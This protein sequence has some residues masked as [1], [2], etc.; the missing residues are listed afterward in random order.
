MFGFD[1]NKGSGAKLIITP[2]V[3]SIVLM[4]MINNMMMM[5]MNLM[6]KMMMMISFS[7]PGC[8]RVELSAYIIYV[9][10]HT[11]YGCGYSS[12]RETMQ[13]GR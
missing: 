3:M 8:E 1:N 4:F 5:I 11:Y 6:V 2:G 13:L 7:S 12:T 10:H 9:C